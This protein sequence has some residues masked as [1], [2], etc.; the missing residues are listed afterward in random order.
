VTKVELRVNMKDTSCPAWEKKYICYALL[1]AKTKTQ[2]KVIYFY[3]G[4]IK[5][6]LMHRLN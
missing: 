5:K 2:V 6:S 1:L 4:K 3:I